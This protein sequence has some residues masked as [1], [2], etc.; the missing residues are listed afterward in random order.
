MSGRRRALP[1]AV[2]AVA[3]LLIAVLLVVPFF[4]KERGVAAAIP[5]PPPLFAAALIEIGPGER[6]CMGKVTFAPGGE[7]AQVKVAT[8]ARPP[9]PFTLTLA[10]GSYRATARQ[11]ATYSDNDTVSL[12]VAAP[13]RAVRGDAC[14][15][16][17]GRRRLALYGAEDR[18]R[19]RA[20]TTVG[21]KPEKANFQLALYGEAD[22]NLGDRYDEVTEHATAFRPGGPWVAWLMSVLVLVGVPAALVGAV[23]CAAREDT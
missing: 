9:V 1:A 8:Y 22:A 5:Q 6:A 16:N 20:V 7:V 21:G 12:A 11:P 19:R 14:V 4:G 18:T 2:M 23:A 13:D 3:L 10:A 15:R 17:D